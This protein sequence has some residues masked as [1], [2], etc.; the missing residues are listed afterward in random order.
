MRLK[1]LPVTA[2]EVSDCKEGLSLAAELL[3]GAGIRRMDEIMELFKETGPMRGAMLL[4]ADSL[5]RLEPDRARGVRATY[6]DAASLTDKAGEDGKNHFAEALVL[7]T[8]VANAPG[9][10][11]EICVSDDPGYVTGYVAT[12]EIGYHRIMKMKR[13]GDPF[14]GRIF[15]YRGPREAVD[16]TIGYLERRCVV[17]EGA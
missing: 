9:I 2:H 13:P 12:R 11:G 1:A 10:V 3:K 7:S 16:E 4:D 14:G 5:E 17:V 8:K 6:M 15:L